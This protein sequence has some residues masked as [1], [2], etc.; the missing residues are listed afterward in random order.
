[1][2]KLN[3]IT[4]NLVGLFISFSILFLIFSKCLYVT[5]FDNQLAY[6]L[7]FITLLHFGDIFTSLVAKNEEHTKVPPKIDI[8]LAIA[9]KIFQIHVESFL[10]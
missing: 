9:I 5:S 1:M 10:F 2:I 8:E 3:R 6:W 7:S 4:I